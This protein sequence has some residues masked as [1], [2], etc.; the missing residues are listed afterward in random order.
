MVDDDDNVSNI[1]RER[2]QVVGGRAGI[3]PH[4]VETGERSHCVLNTSIITIII[5]KNIITVVIKNIITII[6]HH[7]IKDG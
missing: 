6:N 7:P 1:Q 2:V 4:R 5:I 3:E